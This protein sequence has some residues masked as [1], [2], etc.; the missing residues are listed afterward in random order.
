MPRREHGRV[1]LSR[2][3]KDSAHG[4]ETRNRNPL[5]VMIGAAVNIRND[6]KVT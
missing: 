3:F 1:I 2:F 6:K 4:A 5:S